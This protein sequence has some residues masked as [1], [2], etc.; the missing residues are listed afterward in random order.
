VIPF[1]TV[2]PPSTNV[3]EPDDIK[4]SLA[5][6]V[7]ILIVNA[8][9]KFEDPV[10]DKAGIRLFPLLIVVATVVLS[11]PSY[12]KFTIK[13][14]VDTVKDDDCTIVEPDNIVFPIFL[15]LPD[16]IAEPVNGNVPPI[17]DR[18]KD[19][20]NALCAKDEL[21][22]FEANEALTAF[23]IY[24]AVTAFCANEEL[25]TFSTYDAVKAYEAD[26]ADVA[27]DAI[28]AEPA[29]VAELAVFAFSAYV[30]YEDDTAVSAFV[31]LGE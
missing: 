9:L 13:D 12:G 17:T 6:R 24:D 19:A 26:V 27:A 22:E 20:V 10:T 15:K 29:V 8:P 4:L 5:V 2:T 25:T 16:I 3:A 21:I 14:P 7:P 11:A 31:E 28:V 23:K 1:F 30:E 18:A